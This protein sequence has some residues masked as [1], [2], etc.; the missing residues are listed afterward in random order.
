[1]NDKIHG[2]VLTITDYKEADALLQVLTNEY[3]VISLVAKAAKKLNSK[4]HFLSMCNYEFIIDYKEGKTIFSIHNYKLINNFFIDDDIALASFESILAELSIKNK[5]IMAYKQLLFVLERLNNKNKYLLG[6]MYFVYMIKQFGITPIVDGCAIC[7]DKK[8]VSLS[9]NHG[10]FL[11]NKHLG[12]EDVF[13]VNTLKKFRL[14]V[15]ADFT[16]YEIIKDYEYDLN[17]FKII[18]EFYL[19]NSGLRLKSYEFYKSLV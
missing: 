10:G 9:N 12:N 4:N 13:P 11:C 6:S 3:G 17:D 8:V 15:K 18:A 19:E 5:E 16:N 1:M 14:I 2:I 7:G